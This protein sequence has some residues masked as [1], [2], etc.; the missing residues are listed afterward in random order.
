[1]KTKGFIIG[2]FL[3]I[4]H[5]PVY[6]QSDF[7]EKLSE[8]KNLTRVTITKTLFSLMPS[9][10]SE[11]VDMNGVDIAHLVNK[12]DHLDIFTSED[13]QVIQLMR[14]GMKKHIKNN[15]A[16]E[17]LM[18]VKDNESDV[19]FY[20]EKGEGKL[21]KSLIMF[22]D[23]SEDCVLMRILGSFTLEDIQKVTSN[24]N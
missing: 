5:I 15:K 23:D 7:F 13:S 21:I 20:I 9:F 12:L 11:Q 10:A 3:I 22:V 4:I 2:L 14:E 19:A 16:Y 18:L 24:V 17:A 8:E 1:M 6:S